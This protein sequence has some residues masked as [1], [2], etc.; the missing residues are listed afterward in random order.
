[1]HNSWA[2]LL[3]FAVSRTTVLTSEEIC[4]LYNHKTRFSHSYITF[5]HKKSFT[6]RITI[7]FSPAIIAKYGLLSNIKGK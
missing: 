3:V 1:M 2:R 5:N 4:F 6:I 7:K